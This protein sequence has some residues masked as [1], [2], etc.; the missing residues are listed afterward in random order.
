M[1]WLP[2]SRRLRSSVSRKK[3][4][5]PA[6]RKK[7]C[8][9]PQIEEKEKER[10][11]AINKQAEEVYD[12]AV[13][14]YKNKKFAEAKKK[15][16]EVSW[17]IPDYKAT[18][19]YL[20][21]ID[22]DAQEE[23][24]RVARE[25]Q[26][27]LQQQRWEETV[28]SKKQEAQ[29]QHE[30]EVKELQHKKELQEQA[31]FL[32]TAAVNL[33]DQ[34]KM[35]EAL[36]K[37]NE[38]EKL[39]PDFKDTRRY[40]QKLAVMAHLR[41]H[42]FRRSS[43]ALCP[44]SFRALCP[45]SLP[46]L[47]RVSLRA[48]LRVS[49]RALLRVSLRALLRVSLR[50]RRAKQSLQL[51]HIRSKVAATLEDQQKQAQDIAA[52]AEKSAQLYRQIADIADDRPTV[53][54]KRK[55]AQVDEILNSLKE[56]KERLLRQMQEEQWKEQRNESKARQNEHKAEAEKMYQ[57][58]LDY[59]RSH[60]YAKARIKFLGLENIIPDYKSTRRYL[61]RIDEDLKRSN[62]E[63][64]TGYEKAQAE[65]LKVLQ[66]K[67]NTEQLRRAQ[68]EKEKQHNI[69]EQQQASLK[70]LAGKASDINDEI[71][72]LSKTQDYEGMKA[73]FAQLEGTVT[74][75]I[76][77]KN[78][79]AKFKDQQQREKELSRESLRERNAVQRAQKQEDQQIHAYYNVQPLK[80]Y[81][82]V[83][84]SQTDNADQYKRRDIM[85]EQNMLFNEGV[86]RYEHKKYTQAKL[87]FG[88]LADQHDR[89][90][91]AWLKKVDRAITRELLKSQAGEERERTAFLQD[92]VKAQRQLVII[93][94]RERQRQKK[95]TEELERQKRLYEDERSLQI[96][97]EETMKAQERERQRQEAKRLELEKESEKQQDTLRFH[98]IETVVK[99]PAVPLPCSLQHL[100]TCSAAAVMPRRC[101]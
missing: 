74:A 29:R 48:L 20:A 60:E 51:R 97:K 19:K 52:L 1:P 67:E 96:R 43:R 35:D 55:M 10:K 49:L 57:E 88:E 21:R 62:V 79:M 93:Q 18:M 63:A 50:A 84:S 2:N 85:Q 17:V 32:Y 27:A 86:D 99:Q 39:S 41:Q 98:K 71:I 24:E 82:P 11:E 45:P 4:K 22:H 66:E 90:A 31:Q 78:E 76:K 47:L 59:L 44:P 72:R 13:D 95:L 91:E 87:L 77:L 68:E 14:L 61:S 73:K 28:E 40:L 3:L 8:G 56:S 101:C 80:E 37:F 38:I 7:Q 89:R 25:Q 64:V 69:E 92:Q 15:F 54:T 30:L 33:F 26:K 53:Q 100:R 75:L 81:R 5:L 65:N 9:W 6:P 23:Q 34:K 12:E 42:R 94:E 46:A 83:L 16:E 70:E 36:E 58:G